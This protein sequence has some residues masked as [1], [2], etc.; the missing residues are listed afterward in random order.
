MN[1]K[2]IDSFFIQQGSSNTI[3]VRDDNAWYVIKEECEGS[4]ILNSA[5]VSQHDTFQQA[6]DA[7][8][9]LKKNE[10]S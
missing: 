4:R 6:K 1:N 3:R 5:I 9:K 2:R 7:L 8:S 10:A